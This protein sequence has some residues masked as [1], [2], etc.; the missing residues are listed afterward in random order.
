MP[1]L[2]QQDFHIVDLEV[3]GDLPERDLADGVEELDI[4]RALQ[5]DL[6]QVRHGL[7]DD[8]KEF[9]AQELS[10]LP[11]DSEECVTTSSRGCEFSGLEEQQQQYPFLGQ[12]HQ[13]TMRKPCDIVSHSTSL[14]EDYY[15]QREGR[16]EHD[17][18]QQQHSQ[19][20]GMRQRGA[21]VTAISQSDRRVRSCRRVH[22]V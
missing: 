19:I 17:Y 1:S 16:V 6:S 15:Q 7:S 20:S 13:E 14:L 18:F 22:I 11:D 9:A 3:P 21:T 4:W 8:F 12:L 10:W 5:P 2:A